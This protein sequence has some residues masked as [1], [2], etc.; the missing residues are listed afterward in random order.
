MIQKPTS[1]GPNLISV[2]W[3]SK[4]TGLSLDIGESYLKA[5]GIFLYT[6]HAQYEWMLV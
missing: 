2:D 4:V 1:T 3:F 6:K 5:Y